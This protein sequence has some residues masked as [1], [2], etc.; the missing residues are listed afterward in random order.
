MQNDCEDALVIATVALGVA[1]G[2]TI[3]VAFT[4]GGHAVG[5]IL[6]LFAI[7]GLSLALLLWCIQ[8]RPRRR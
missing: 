1:L 7:W 4:T 8:R 6:T 2:L 3:V 5:M